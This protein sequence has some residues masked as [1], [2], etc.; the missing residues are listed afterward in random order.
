VVTLR[1]PLGLSPAIDTVADFFRRVVAEDSDGL[2]E[3]FTRDALAIQTGMSGQAQSPSA[4]LWWEQRFR[5]LDYGKL[6]GEPIYRESE[7]E[8]Y[9]AEDVLDAPRHP[10]IQADTLGDDDVVIRVPIMTPRIATDRLFGDELVVWL[11]RDGAG[12]RIYRILEDFQ[13][14]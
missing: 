8:I 3:L 5:R 4:V 13:L 9:R 12:F 7:L 1:T 14:Q 10:P 11:R 6:A 2:G